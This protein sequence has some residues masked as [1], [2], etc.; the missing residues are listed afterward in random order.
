MKEFSFIHTGDLHLDS[1]F[2]GIS[3]ISEKIS[4]ELVGATFN[5]FNRIIDLCIEKKV[6]FLL[7]AGDIY[8]GSD[9][10]LRAQ[11]KFRDGL[12][13]LSEVGINT[14][15]VHG[16][17]DPLD[18]WSVNL[19]L[20]EN[21][22]IFSG[23]A[24]EKITVEKNGEEIAQICGISFPTQ[25]IKTNLSNKFQKISNSEK[26]LYTIGLLHCNVGNNT[27]HYPYAPCTLQ[28][29][30]SRNFDYWALGHIHKKSILNEE[31]P[32]IIYPGNSQGL[33][34]KECGAK[35]CFLV[36]VYTKGETTYDFIETDS[37]RWFVEELSITGLSVIEDF[38]SELNKCIEKIR[39]KANGR[40]SICRIVLSG[41]GQLHSMITKK[42]VLDDI[43]QEIRENVRKGENQF[44][45]IE[46]F[47]NNT[48]SEID[49][50]SLLNRKDFI[51]DLIN[52]FEEFHNGKKEISE[53]KK[54][55][56]LLFLSAGGRKFLEP[57][58]DEHLHNLI[59]KAETICLD[60]FPEEKSL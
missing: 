47:V 39:K 42:G 21:V 2:K 45:W 53:L 48:N 8:D 12:K 58:D 40:K 54:S 29:L 51:G 57:I 20:P 56:E 34:P 15:V 10:S 9:R 50:D 16:N 13:R 6:D 3:E 38:I 59:K 37:I 44:V 19:N 28:D 33:S 22:H 11:L 35:G 31:N 41:R 52:L 17:H 43:L 26:I 1:P 24:V 4:S 55:L 18:G 27:G 14:Y 30:I 49:R 46:S 60:K 25:E 23:K 36:N 32:V 5:S 7:I